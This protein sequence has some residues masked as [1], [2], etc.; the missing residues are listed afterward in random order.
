[1]AS[2]FFTKIL[3]PLIDNKI[4]SQII[5]HL[6]VQSIDKLK[7]TRSNFDFQVKKIKNVNT[8][9]L[10][11]MDLNRAVY[12]WASKFLR[13]NQGGHLSIAS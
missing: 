10:N 11:K 6:I 8:I 3:K 13:A 9:K 7:K 12:L 1:M 2:R 5:S 4:Q